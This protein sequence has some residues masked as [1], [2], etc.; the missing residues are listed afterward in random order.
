MIDQLEDLRTNPGQ[1]L[2]Q[3]QPKRWQRQFV[4]VPWAWVER[5]RAA[6][7]VGTYRLALV[8]IYESWRQGGRAIALSNV[9]AF[10]AG[11]PARSKWRALAELESLGLIQVKRQRRRAP[12][13]VLQHLTREPS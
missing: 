7:R 5:L 1:G 13:V 11:L 2:K 8:L 3:V 10:A 12:R 6:R 9:F 4:R